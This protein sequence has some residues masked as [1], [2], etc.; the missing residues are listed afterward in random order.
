MADEAA[1]QANKTILNY[2][3]KY[4][5]SYDVF[6]FIHNTILLSWQ[7]S[8]NSIPFTNKLKSIKHSVKQYYTPQSLTG[9]RTSQSPG[10]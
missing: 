3:I 2:I 8:W 5:S 6:N 1:D 7:K 9:A 10:Q 4:T